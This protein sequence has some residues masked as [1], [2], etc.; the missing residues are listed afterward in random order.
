MKASASFSYAKT[1]GVVIATGEFRLDELS[2]SVICDG[3]RR[4][5]VIGVE[6]ENDDEPFDETEVIKE[7]NSEYFMRLNR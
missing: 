3:C 6:P 1:T 4:Y 2:D 5:I 7:A